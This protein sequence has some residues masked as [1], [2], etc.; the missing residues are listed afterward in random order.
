MVAIDDLGKPKTLP[1]LAIL[2]Q[3]LKTPH[4][5]LLGIEDWGLGEIDIQKLSHL[6]ENP[7]FIKALKH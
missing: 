2:L 3:D 7:T 4:E 5:E 1:I 6:D